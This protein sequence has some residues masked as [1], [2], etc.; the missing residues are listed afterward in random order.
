MALQ[1]ETEKVILMQLTNA[2]ADIL[3]NET[4]IKTLKESNEQNEK[5]KLR[6]DQFKK[7][8]LTF[9][10]EKDFYRGLATRASILFFAVSY[11]HQVEPMYQFSLVWYRKL[12]I[13]SIADADEDSDKTTRMTNIQNCFQENLFNNICRSLL[14][15]D[16][17]LF[18]FLMCTKIMIQD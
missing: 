2:G 3:E 15:K 13:K 18:S 9:N 17:L 6:L 4:V 8:E 10:K 1:L 14:E 16:K 12:F 7:D 11:L 5:T